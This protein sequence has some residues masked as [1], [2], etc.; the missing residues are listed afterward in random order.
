MKPLITLKQ[1]NF[2][3][4]PAFYEASHR[5]LVNNYDGSMKNEIEE[6]T[7]GGTLLDKGSL[8]NFATRVIMPSNVSLGQRDILGGW[9]E[10]KLAGFLL[11]EIKTPVET[12]LEVLTIY[13]DIFDPSF[14]GTL[15]NDLL[16]TIDNRKIVGSSIQ[17]GVINPRTGSCG[18]DYMV[19]KPVKVITD[20]VNTN[21]YMAR[22][23]DVMAT[24]QKISV[25]E[26]FLDI[27]TRAKESGSDALS[28]DSD[29]SSYLSKTLTRYKYALV[30]DEDN[31]GYGV[32]HSPFGKAVSSL[33]VENSNMS[34]VVEYI[35]K[36]SQYAMN[37]MFT[38][39]ELVS[40]FG[41]G[42]RGLNDITEIKGAVTGP[43]EN[44]RNDASDWHGWSDETNIAFRLNDR[45]GKE[46]ANRL[47]TEINIEIKQDTLG[48]PH[49]VPSSV[50]VMFP[51]MDK[52]IVMASIDSLCNTIAVEMVSMIN[53]YA[54][55]YHISIKAQAFVKNRISIK[56]GN[57]NRE[58]F[59]APSF[60]TSV[61]TPMAGATSDSLHSFSS[62]MMSMIEHTFSKNLKGKVLNS[63][64]ISV[65]YNTSMPSQFI[66]DPV[67][68]IHNP[69]AASPNPGK[70]KRD[71][72]V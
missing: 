59:I 55:T 45:L 43:M 60:C 31:R 39:G 52:D 2:I 12:K 36:H 16:F 68:N 24:M 18:R 9:N 19:V 54:D 46:M 42:Q 56:L 23:S 40:M 5:P 32:E 17:S 37:G 41:H 69:S 22:P 13:S 65:D 21:E 47:I 61:T 34:H 7:A 64:G 72:Y 63:S 62:S 49:V 35:K 67:G 70:P 10:K 26:D 15:S 51:N 53:L 4:Q 1:C 11:F 71:V 44:T 3:V 30:D 66:E 50:N 25:G 27:R 29:T 20:E 38:W 28:V 14:R 57:R 48:R 33:A 6:V 58:V 8:S